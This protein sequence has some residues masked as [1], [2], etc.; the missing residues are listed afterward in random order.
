MDSF[1]SEDSG[2][3]QTLSNWRA[4][5][6]LDQ[7]SFIATAAQLF[8]S[9][10]ANDYHLAPT[11]PAIDAGTSLPSPN[12]PPTTDLDGT[13][14]PSGANWDIGAYERSSA[15]D[16]TPPQLSA[17]TATNIQGNKATITWTTDELAD[18]Q[19]DFGA[20]GY[21]N[22]SALNPTLSPSHSVML[23]GLSSTTL[24][25]YRVRSKDASG[26]P[27][28]SDDFTF[29]TA[30]A[31]TTPPVISNVAFTSLSPNSTAVSWTT[32]EVA[33]TKVRYGFSA[34]YGN[35]SPLNPVF[36]TAHS[37]TLSGLVPGTQYHVQLLSRD[38]SG[39][40]TAS[41]D[42]IFTTS[43]ANSTPTGAAAFW[44]FNESTGATTADAT[45]N[46]HTGTL[47]NGAVFSTA[48]QSGNAVSFDGVDD[49]VRIPRAASLE[50]AVVSLTAWIKIPSGV[51]EA[52]WASV[53]KKTYG[54]D[55]DRPWG[56][57]SLQLSP[58]GAANKVGFFTGISGTDGNTL[59][60]PAALPANVW[61]HIAGTYD[62]ASS[63]KKLYVNG[64]LVASTTVSNPIVNDTTSAGDIYLGQDPGA[65]EA[66]TGTIDGVGVWG[67]IL[68]PGEIAAMAY[69]PVSQTVSGTSGSDTILATRSS[70]QPLQVQVNH[71]APASV[72]L[73]AVNVVQI[74]GNTGT[75][76]LVVTG[77]GGDD[78]ILI[79]AGDVRFGST[80]ISESSVER[81]NFD[82]AGGSDRLTINAA[83]VK[84]PTSQTLAGLSVINSGTLDLA[85]TT[86]LLNYAPGSS[87][88]TEIEDLICT[89]WNNGAW[90]GPGII[91]SFGNAS[92]AALGF[93]DIP[94]QNQIR[95][96]F[97]SYG[98]ATLDGAVN[99]L[100][101]NALAINFGS[102]GKLWADAD[103]N[104]DG[105]VN[106]LDFNLLA[107][108]FGNAAASPALQSSSVLA[109]AL[110]QAAASFQTLPLE[111]RDAQRDDLLDL[112]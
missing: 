32:D 80:L 64:Q 79:D 22:S 97:T 91:T 18:S 65:G 110:P 14:R 92:Q 59:I 69:T 35:T 76:T 82:G 40:L 68:T 9:A 105:N 103:F 3:A 1:V 21:T 19:V 29:T 98:D 6:G 12:Q 7:H 109:N 77:L 90:N 5:T 45:G 70:P 58:Y 108:N 23:S 17:I 85:D 54:N 2:A 63:S 15:P 60:S 112:I 51:T 62:P 48:G 52:D 87:P 33:D 47:Q 107:S 102:S 41:S 111:T 75:D 96:A 10:A 73:N 84:L 39:N 74:N 89:G 42:L 56:S 44:P 8:V 36:T 100:D 37:V 50:P 20:T 67:R 46:A 34:N 61:V 13:M 95:I 72:D 93:A 25:H 55:L 104:F 53:I 66:F 4:Q 78:D 71:Q 99:S 24:Y 106:A 88:I 86:L 28:V 81:I 31:D 27:A 30:A 26:N 11:S 43:S 83:T 49:S 94:S 57:W 38:D 101:F 16:T